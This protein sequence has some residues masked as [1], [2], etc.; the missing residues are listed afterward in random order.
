MA[1]T[2]DHRSRLITNWLITFIY[3]LLFAIGIPWYWPTDD[4]TIW[5]GMPAWVV[6]A[7]MASV[8]ISLLTALLFYCPWT[9]QKSYTPGKHAE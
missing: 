5:L 9:D 1:N 4:R 8:A 2:N 7:I 6:I 3:L